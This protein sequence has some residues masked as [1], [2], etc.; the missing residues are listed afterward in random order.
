MKKYLIKFSLC[1]T[2]MTCTI[3]MQVIAQQVVVRRIDFH[4]NTRFDGS[5]LRD[6][7]GV[8]EGKALTGDW[9]DNAMSTLLS[10]YHRQGYYQ[11]RIDS[12]T[13]RYTR[14]STSVDLDIWISEGY[15]VRVGRF[16]VKG[17]EDSIGKRLIGLL[18]TRSGAVFYETVLKED[19]EQILVFLENDGYPL[20][21]VDVESL[22]MV[23]DEDH[24][25]MD[26]VLRID[27][28]PPVTVGSIR[29]EGNRTTKERIILRETRLKEGQIY[30]HREV[31]SARENLKQLVYIQEVG[32]PDVVFHDDEAIVNF[33]IEEGN[34][35]VIDGVLGYHPS[36]REG[37]KG[38]LTGRLQFT[39]RNI[40]GTGRFLDA[41]WEKKDAYSQSMRFGYE[42]PWLLNMPLHLGGEFRQEVRDTTYVERDWHFSVRYV[43]WPSLSMH[44]KGGYNRVLPDSAASYTYDLP[45]SAAWIIALG[46]EYDTFDDPY[47][48]RRG[49]RYHTTVTLG[50]KQNIGPEALIEQGGWKRVVNTR[51]LEADAEAV[52]STF[53]RQILYFG[54]HATEVRTGDRFVPLSHQVR[55]G[56]ARTLRGYAEDA[57]RGTLV[58]WMN[59]EYRFL[60]GRHSR[61]FVFVD[62][63][64]YQRRE[65]DLGM[66]RG[67]KIGYGFGLRLETR[68]GLI[69]IDY[70]LGEGD[71][72]M[73]GKVHVG[74]VGR[75]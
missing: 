1:F 6:A 31:L 67:T 54:L 49:V 3:G 9:P 48:P 2:I 34:A 37:Q 65:E 55:F 42:E 46:I 50:R 69:G 56:G 66:V 39:F 11:A 12:V 20:G 4:G 57:F 26:I 15:P 17:G 47:N 35:N 43:P 52:V 62:G 61:I 25:K 72:P 28:G 30:R 74:L 64:T 23:D 58:A 18:Q 8:Q 19:I 16:E 68:L 24:P 60:L 38:Y 7:I 73:Q 41:Y 21:R 22:S 40:V 13:E 63:G 59:A 14:D 29:A 51:R 70:G 53:S 33:R 71:N 5:A 10:S 45:E 44:L 27:P 32:E 75:F 36:S